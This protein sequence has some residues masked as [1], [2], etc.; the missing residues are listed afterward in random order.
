MP[1]RVNDY[2]LKSAEDRFWKYVDR[3]R[4][5]WNWTGTRFVQGYGSFHIRIAEWLYKRIKAHRYSYELHH[6]KIPNWIDVCHTCDNRRCVNP[7]HLFLG[8]RAD[9][10]K[11]MVSKNRQAKGSRLRTNLN[12]KIVSSLREEYRQRHYT[13]KQLAKR[14]KCSYT[15][16]NYIL[17]RK[18][19]RHI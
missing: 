9:N 15:T 12:E 6:G 7:N 1:I 11:D 19:W 18:T 10:T 13:M 4:N 2:K 14:Y 5:C 16:I 8:S 3:T 17:N